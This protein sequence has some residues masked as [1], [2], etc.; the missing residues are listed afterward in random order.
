MKR[1]KNSIDS[2]KKNNNKDRGLMKIFFSLV[3]VVR[4]LRLWFDFNPTNKIVRIVKLKPSKSLCVTITHT[5]THKKKRL[6][7]VKLA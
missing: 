5:H 7:C 3:K 4:L 6:T 2:D 1:A